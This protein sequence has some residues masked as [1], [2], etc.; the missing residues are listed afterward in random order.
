MY[1]KADSSRI[2]KESYPV[3]DEIAQFL[4]H[5]PD[6]VIE[7]GG[8]TNTMPSAEYCN[9]LS[10]ARA[11]SVTDYLIGKGVPKEQLQYKGY[12]KTEPIIPNDTYSRTA[13]AKNQRVEIKVLRVG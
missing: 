13:R 6:I 1:F 7:I 11:K 9:T 12:G 3:L 2:E 8:H 10:T 4:I 5:N